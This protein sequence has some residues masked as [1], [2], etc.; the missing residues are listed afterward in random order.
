MKEKRDGLFVMGLALA[1]LLIGGALGFW[2]A[3]HGFGEATDGVYLAKGGEAPYE[4]WYSGP[5][6]KNYSGTCFLD[7]QL[8]AERMGAEGNAA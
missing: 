8:V 1:C 6:G 7:A 5:D 2:Y 3:T 4:C